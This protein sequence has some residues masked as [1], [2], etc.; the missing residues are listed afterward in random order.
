VS[1]LDEFAD[2]RFVLR[3]CDGLRHFAIDRSVSRIQRPH[4]I[5]EIKLAVEFGSE[6]FPIRLGD[7]ETRSH[8]LETIASRNP[9][10]LCVREINV[11]VLGVGDL[12]DDLDV[13]YVAINDRDAFILSV[14]IGVIID[15][16]V[17]T[18]PGR[19]ASVNRV[20]IIVID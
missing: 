15:G 19:I 13:N 12:V 2:V 11:L 1:E 3:Q 17:F 14:L 9:G 5:I 7:H 10:R 4:Q 8:R 20:W 16:S 6:L 18:V